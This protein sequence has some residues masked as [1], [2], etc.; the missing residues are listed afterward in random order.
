M[1]QHWENLAKSP[2]NPSHILHSENIVRTTKSIEELFSERLR[3]SVNR[4]SEI[5]LGELFRGDCTI[6]L[7]LSAS[8][9]FLCLLP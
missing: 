7:L 2:Q 9:P 6:F 3:E 4:L 5:T 1:G 8:L